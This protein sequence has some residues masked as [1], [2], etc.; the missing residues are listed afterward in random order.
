MSDGFGKKGL[1]WLAELELP[2]DEQRDHP[3]VR[4]SGRNPPGKDGSP[5]KDHPATGTFSS[6]A[7]R[8]RSR[9][10][11]RY[12]RSNQRV[13]FRRRAQVAIVLLELPTGQP[14]RSTA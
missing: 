11:D 4:Q 9:P 6:R 7:P 1:S 3:R 13:R 12:E 5:D 14:E 10:Q 2:A 8:P